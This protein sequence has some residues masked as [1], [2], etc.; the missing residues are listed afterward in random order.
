MSVWDKA[1]DDVAA[2]CNNLIMFNVDTVKRGDGTFSYNV[3]IL[4]PSNTLARDLVRKIEHGK[5]VELGDLREG[6]FVSDVQ[7]S[8]VYPPHHYDGPAMPIEDLVM[9]LG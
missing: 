2:K 1:L 7:A 9:R 4:V 8:T 3:N 5:P 6:M